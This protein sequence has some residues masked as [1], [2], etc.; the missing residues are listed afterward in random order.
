MSGQTRIAVHSLPDLKNTTDDA[1]PN[2][3]NSLKFRQSHTHAD[4]RLALG[5]TAVLI[6]GVLFYFDWTRGWDLTKPYTAPAVLAYFLL[7]GAFMYWTY[8][9]EKGLIYS[10]E[11]NGEKLQISSH[12]EKHIPIYKLRVRFTS[13]GVWQQIDIQAPF[14][15]WFSA[16]GYLVARPM[17]QFLASEIPP[18]GAADPDAVVEEIGRGSAAGM[19]KELNVKADRVQDVLHQLKAQ[20]TGASAAGGSARRRG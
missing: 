17:Q 9:V 3:I 12:C 6:A 19:P 4:V 14:T 15:R 16:D 5:Y 1:L 10:G 7:N 11:K 18:V 20:A 13:S 8:F 2:Y